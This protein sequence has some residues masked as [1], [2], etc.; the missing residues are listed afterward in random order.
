MGL[1]LNYTI[2]LASRAKVEPFLAA[3]RKEGLRRRWKKPRAG[4]PYVLELFPHPR[5]EPVLLDF[6]GSLCCDCYVKS[7]FAPMRTHV[8]LVEFLRALRP[9]AKSMKVEDEFGYWE[10]GDPEVLKRHRRRFDAAWGKVK[11]RRPP[12]KRSVIVTTGPRGA[13]VLRPVGPI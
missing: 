9:L 2:R 4:A 5:C 12:K 10:T 6:S 8:Q 7:G 13:V 3:A 1:G 11:S